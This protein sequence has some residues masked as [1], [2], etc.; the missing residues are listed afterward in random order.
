MDARAYASRMVF[1]D[2]PTRG[3]SI[4][5]R[6]S[7]CFPG[8]HLC[9]WPSRARASARSP[10]P[11]PMRELIACWTRV[12]LSEVGVLIEGET[13]TGKE[14]VA[15]AIHAAKPARGRPLVVCDL[16]GVSRSLID[17]TVRPRARRLHRRPR[18][19]RLRLRG[20]RRA[21]T[22]F[23]DEIG[24]A[25][26]G[27]AA[28]PPAARSSGRQVEAGRRA[29]RTRVGR[30]VTRPPPT[31]TSPAEVR[32]GRFREDLFPPL[33]VVRRAGCRVAAPSGARHPAPGPHELLIRAGGAA[34]TVTPEAM[35]AAHRLLL[36]GNRARA[37]RN[38]L[39]PRAVAARARRH[40]PPH[41][42]RAARPL[43]AADGD[44]SGNAQ[45][46]P[47]PGTERPTAPPLQRPK[48]RMIAAWER[49][50]VARLLAA[51]GGNVSRAPAR[52]PRAS[53]APAHPQARHRFARPLESILARQ[54]HGGIA[55]TWIG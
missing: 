5:W 6:A 9:D 35:S 12:A 17:R 34:V 42:P 30:G 51:S 25:G 55:T 16:A 18:R 53:P 41:R 2:S 31:A 46:E 27:R 44:G 10:A 7:A 22:I 21:G 14:L 54:S 29:R 52:R 19:A 50:W 47:E 26:A 37:S 8:G 49:A 48:E 28:A 40:R 33:A 13:G 23:I 3:R 38:V 45:P 43:R 39:R 32:A 20:A 4:R 11:L 1:L 15:E 24:R 36:A